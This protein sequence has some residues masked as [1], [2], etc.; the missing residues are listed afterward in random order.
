VTS[1]PPRAGRPPRP[2]PTPTSSARQSGQPS[3]FGDRTDDA[4]I[5]RAGKGLILA[6]YAALRA[7]RL[8]PLENAAVV[9]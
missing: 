2:L 8:Y 7:I 4:H 9:K 5:R 6:F 3:P 1:N